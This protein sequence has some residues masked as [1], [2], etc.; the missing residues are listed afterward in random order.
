MSSH[1]A[2]Q[3][4]I[5][6][7]NAGR[8][9]EAE[10]ICRQLLA[11]EP[12]LAEALHLLGVVQH[13]QGR[14]ELATQFYG[15]A[16]ALRP[17]WS[18]AL[19]NHG[20]ALRMLG[21]LDEAIAAHRRALTLAPPTARLH[22]N[23]GLA[24]KASG[25]IEMAIAEYRR[26]VALNPRYARAWSNLGNCLRETNQLDD[27]IVALSNA[28]IADP[29]FAEAHNNLATALRAKGRSDEAIAA[30]RKAV[31][32]RP[33][34]ADAYVT[35]SS[36]LRDKG[37]YEDAIVACRQ[38]IAIKPDFI[39]GHTNLCTLLKE[40]GRLDEA[41]AAARR[42]VELEPDSAEA[43]Y[44]LALVLLLRGDFDEGWREHEWRWLFKDFPAT[45]WASS[46]PQW[47]GSDLAGR[48]IL[49]YCEQGFG[50]IL[51][52]IRYV[53]MVAQRGGTIVV[54]CPQDLLRL[55][56]SMK[57]VTTWVSF[58][59]PSGLPPYDC[60]C[61]LMSL[62]LVFQTKLE[63]IP[64]S[65]GYLS[66]V[67]SDVARWRRRLADEPPGFKV[68]LVWAGRPEHRNDHNRSIRLSTLAPLS[69]AAGVNFYSLQKGEAGRQA[70]DPPEG[71]KLVDWSSEL[72]DFAQTAALIANLDLVISVDSAVAHLTGAL[73]K[74]VW[75]LAPFVTDWRWPPG[76]NESPWYSSIRIFQQRSS[77]R[78]DEVIERVA[79]AL[80]M[81]KAGEGG[82]TLD[83]HVGNV[84]LYH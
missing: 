57:G 7:L 27:A 28:I 67:E 51:Q 78:W 62:P 1:Q 66:P 21:R 74:P 16:I 77:G 34:F 35:L 3:A 76:R 50:D 38:A 6:H 5:E 73:G 23:L 80:S 10:S 9:A 25:R 48:T 26:A 75:L 45:R 61:P 14:H 24:L 22:Y 56:Q 71:L 47:D 11:K 60:H 44:V 15:R 72:G 59:N 83:I 79:G 17:G 53:P 55:F 30:C 69:K 81:L 18:D 82:R 65:A 8:F 58:D 13:R 46:K 29:D 42:A 20:E 41:I 37:L 32:L 43:H 52:F 2:I 19:S 33:N 39:E 63:S 12:H 64:Q 31:A 84:T 70:T 40:M 54:F 68:G 36:C 4:A 49:L